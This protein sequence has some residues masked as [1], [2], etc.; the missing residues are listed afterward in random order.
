MKGEPAAGRLHCM[1]T[2]SGM[3][4]NEPIHLRTPLTAASDPRK[5]GKEIWPPSFLNRTG[6]EEKANKYASGV[7][8]RRRIVKTSFEN[9]TKR[10]V[11]L[12]HDGAHAAP[13]CLP[14]APGSSLPH[15]IKQ[16]KREPGGNWAP[17]ASLRWV[18]FAGVA[19]ECRSDRPTGEPT[20]G[21]SSRRLL[22][23]TERG[24]IELAEK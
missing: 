2:K 5:R 6:R 14:T 13:P 12:E 17:S 8:A 3:T 18:R 9:A 10:N 19:T 11:A 7:L 15:V 21:A 20:E 23:V 22:P 4:Q 16:E 1:P 24:E